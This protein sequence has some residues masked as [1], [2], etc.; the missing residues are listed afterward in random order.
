MT[1]VLSPAPPAARPQV[2]PRKARP[3]VPPLSNGDR[4]TRPEF[5]ARY[6]QM[7][8]SVKAEL[9]EGIVYMPPPAVSHTFH[10]EPHSDFI[11]WLSFY[12]AFTP[13]VVSGD[14]GSLRMDL[15][16]MPQPDAYLM[17]P[18]SR[19]G[20]AR[21]DDDNYV[22]GAPELIGEISASSASYDLHAK[23]N[24]YRRNGVREYVV[25]RTY[26]IEIDY[27]ILRSGKFDRL[28][29]G[30]DGLIRSE[31]FPGLWLDPYA[32]MSGELAG[33]MKAVQLGCA[34]PEHA[35]FAARVKP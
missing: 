4:L 3:S 10:S 20:Q 32:L 27:F 17:I 16:N 25:W 21:I 7:P 1:A 9:V 26:D 22:A 12:K 33:V 31:I 30:P 13:G 24:A 2:I 29:P 11:G 6:E 5:E 19:G 15:D 18:E 35:A 14:N 34:T 23:L 28:L 8:E